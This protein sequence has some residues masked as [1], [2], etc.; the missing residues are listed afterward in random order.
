M[1]WSILILPQKVPDGEQRHQLQNALLFR[2]ADINTR[3][4]SA[5]GTEPALFRRLVFHLQQDLLNE[6]SSMYREYRDFSKYGIGNEI[7]TLFDTT[8][9]IT[10][11]I[12]DRATQD[13]IS[14]ANLDEKNWFE[15]GKVL[16]EG[17]KT[18][19]QGKHG[20]LDREKSRRITRS[21]SRL[22]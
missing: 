16:V 9:K 4:S 13:V 10:R 8:W 3:V 22:Q 5:L 12:K 7:R 19:K 18:D 11:E 20:K 21:T 6:P 14:I 1:L 17:V 15:I 2:I